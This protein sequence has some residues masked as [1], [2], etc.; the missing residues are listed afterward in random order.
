MMESL[1]AIP[2]STN[3]GGGIEMVEGGRKKDREKT[4]RTKKNREKE[5]KEE[6]DE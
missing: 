3:R 1:L 2:I 5:L 6:K 4:E